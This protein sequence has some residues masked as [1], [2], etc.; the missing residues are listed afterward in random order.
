MY[1]DLIRYLGAVY[2]QDEFLGE[3]V[4]NVGNSIHSG[5]VVVIEENETPFGI[6]VMRSLFDT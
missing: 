6:K 1:I 2:I 5:I 4:R 3:G